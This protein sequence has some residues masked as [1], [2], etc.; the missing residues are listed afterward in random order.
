MH[1]YEIRTIGDPVLKQRA[2]EVEDFDGKLAALSEGMT[3][4]MYQAVGCGLAAPQVGVQRRVV[5]YDMGDGPHV[6]IN[7]E[8]VTSKGTAVFEEGCL[9]IPGMR[10]EIERP[11]VITVRGFDL[12]GREVVLEA[13]DFFARMLLHEVDHLDGV[14]TIDRLDSK[15][16]KKALRAIAEQDL[17]GRSV[18]HIAGDL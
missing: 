18:S 9:S 8:V 6:I 12:D 3:E 7:P 10:F 16:R 4:S 2:R 11:A 14:L 5:T 13:D 17:T 15:E 1:T